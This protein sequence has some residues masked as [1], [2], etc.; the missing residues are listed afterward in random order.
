M[1]AEL[2]GLTQTQLFFKLNST[3]FQNYKMFCL[4]GAFQNFSIAI[5]S[6]V[7]RPYTINMI[8]GAKYTFVFGVILCAPS[9]SLRDS[10]FGN[11]CFRLHFSQSFDNRVLIFVLL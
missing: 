4:M 6:N 10:Q 5:P 3:F 2:L 9:S 8:N 11:P 1:H 7:S